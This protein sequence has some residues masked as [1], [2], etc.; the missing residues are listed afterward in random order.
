MKSSKNITKK[1]EKK[2]KRKIGI[3]ENKASYKIVGDFKISE[4]ELISSYVHCE[5]NE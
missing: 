5:N 1:Y 2:Q 4:K 3:L